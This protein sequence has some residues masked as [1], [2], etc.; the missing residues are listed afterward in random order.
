MNNRARNKLRTK[1]GI[2]LKKVEL[3]NC[4]YT[5]ARIISGSLFQFRQFKKH[6]YP[7][8]LS[9]E[10]KGRDGMQEWN[11]ILDEIIYCF[12]EIAEDY[13]LCPDDKYPESQKTYFNRINNGKQLF[14]RYLEDLWD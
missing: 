9:H 5:L 8:N 14:I 3:W 13:P 10:N 4:G 6:S 2:K 7:P 12:N 11:N 1:K